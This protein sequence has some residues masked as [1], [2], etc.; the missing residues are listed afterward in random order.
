MKRA[1]VLIL[2]LTLALA[3]GGMGTAQAAEPG[4]PSHPDAIIDPATP[5]RAG[6]VVTASEEFNASGPNSALFTD[7]YLPHWS[8]SKGTQARYEVSGGTLKL[9]IDSDQEPW[10]PNYD[11]STRVSSLQTY[12]RDYLHK[13]TKYPGIAQKTTPFRGHLQKYGY[14]EVRAKVAS[15]GGLH[16][17]WW[18]TGANQDL[19]DGDGGKSRQSGEVD[20]FEV[21]GRHNATRA[22]SAIHPWGDLGRLWPWTATLTDGE[23][24][25]S[26]DFHTYGFEWT[27]S[28]MKMYVD[29]KLGYSTPLSPAYPM[30]TY[31]GIYEKREADSWTGPFDASVSYPK[32]FEID[33]FRAYQ[34]DKG[35]FPHTYSA[36]DG[37]MEGQSRANWGVARWVGGAG[38]GVTLTHVYAPSAGVYNFDLEFR[39][40]EARDL[41]VTVNTSR[42]MHFSGLST[43]SFRGKLAKL[44]FGAELKEGWNTIRLA[45]PRGNA[46]D[47]G[48]LRLLGR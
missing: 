37:V 11:G 20:I 5:A 15:G 4:A 47:I 19:A 22:Q 6:M 46:P 42:T 31:L 25:L 12:Q 9:R 30:L 27:P 8:L 29:G 48:Q 23:M 2:A 35:Q 21:L 36:S 45:N 40:E 17:A 41:D 18:M 24:D 34:F 39:S 10:D 13:W 28:G 38:N 33:Y 3:G 14:F 7:R 16:S 43:G 44:P 26:K 32:V 1:K